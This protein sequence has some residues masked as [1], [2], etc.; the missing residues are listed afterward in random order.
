[1][2]HPKGWDLPPPEHHQEFEVLLLDLL[3]AMKRPRTEPNLYG[4]NGQAQHGVDFTLEL[5][6]GLHGY[7][8]KRVDS[9]TFA[10]FE[11]EVNK[12][13]AFPNPL[14]AFTVLVTFPNNTHVQDAVTTLSLRRRALGLFPVA[15]VFWP[16]IRDWLAE[17]VDVLRAHYREITPELEDLL[18]GR[19]R[20]IDEELPGTHLEVH[21]RPGHT[22]VVVHPGPGG[23]PFTTT[24][25]GEGVVER[26]SSALRDGREVTFKDGEFDL[27]LPASLEAALGARAGT[28][29]LTMAPALNGRKVAVGVVVHPRTQHHTMEMFKRR[30]ARAP[31]STPAT[32]TFV[33]H[34][35]ARQEVLVEGDRVALRWQIDHWTEESGLQGSIR[36]DRAYSGASV[37]SALA[38]ERILGVLDGGA[39]VGIFAAGLSIVW[40]NAAREKPE[41]EPDLLP[42]L[43]VLTALADA[44]G[45]DLD[46]SDGL[47]LREVS[48]AASL[49]GLFEMGERRLSISGSFKFV[50]DTEER[51]AAMKGFLGSAVEPLSATIRR[52]GSSIV[53]MGKS[54]PFPPTSFHFPRI[55]VEPDVRARL[56]AAST[57]P[58]EAEF[59]VPPGTV[60]VESL[61]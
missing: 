48:E 12:T 41:G 7:Q 11:A 3:K 24:F 18:L 36:A 44:A 58:V 34:G 21:A 2:P 22:D 47:P 14:R 1:M 6:D 33:R 54:R 49:L 28:A 60:A 17:H 20:R 37:Q 50:A 27:R 26:F 39:Y 29:T 59:T 46:L 53:F 35:T 13:I 31:D 19:A 23:V 25:I 38:A 9:F 10:E 15:I 55:E 56:L 57:A 52:E 30:A 42:A 45:W 4:R 5:E 8:S 51:L 61:D 32:L 43:E 16:T 40:E